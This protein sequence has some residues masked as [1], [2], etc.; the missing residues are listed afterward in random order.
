MADFLGMGEQTSFPVQ[1]T[2]QRQAL[3][4][5][6][7]T[8][9]TT[10]HTQASSG[11]ISALAREANLRS[12]QAQIELDVDRKLAALSEGQEGQEQDPMGVLTRDANAYLKAGAVKKGTDLLKAA[13]DINQK[14][15]AAA[16]RGIQAQAAKEKADIANAQKIATM[17]GNV[18]N[19]E[20]WNSVKD[21]MRQMSPESRAAVDKLGAY[22]PEKAAGLQRAM[23][24]WKD[25]KMAENAEKRTSIYEQI[26]D[27]QAK[28]DAA[29]AEN[30]KERNQIQ[31]NREER[32]A[33]QGGR[34]GQKAAGLPTKAELADAGN[35]LK[36]FN[37]TADESDVMEIA[38]EARIRVRNNPGVTPSMATAQ[39]IQERIR[40]GDIQPGKVEPGMLWG[41]NKTPGQIF[42]PTKPQQ[43]PSASKPEDLVKGQYYQ[44]PK[45][46]VKYLGDKKFAVV[47]G[48]DNA[49]PDDGEEE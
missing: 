27:N 37:I 45:G 43:L 17:L 36:N 39:V 18:T 28:R 22:S 20:E 6:A 38:Q 12:D 46:V 31:K 47:G 16:A 1:L 49:P 19:E 33:K 44:S 14:Q 11:Y 35:Q 15:S 21:L 42:S 24:S 2:E 26:K 32:L 41:T 5:L 4:N 34:V 40:K 23:T 13:A 9:A 3:A 7:N 25:R 10:E 48:E 29:A 8:Q 30:A